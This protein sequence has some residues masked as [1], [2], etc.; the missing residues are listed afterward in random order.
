MGCL[1]FS[2]HFNSIHRFSKSLKKC[3]PKSCQ[4]DPIPTSLIFDCLTDILH[5]V[6]LTT[7]IFLPIFLKIAIVRP[8]LRKNPSLTLNDLHFKK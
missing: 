4:L 7:G 5:A 2:Q 3:T 1:Y 8:L 6:T